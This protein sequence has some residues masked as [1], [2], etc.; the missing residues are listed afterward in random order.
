[1]RHFIALATCAVA[2]GPARGLDG[3]GFAARLEVQA[4][5]AVVSKNVRTRMSS[6]SGAL[7][8]SGWASNDV[9]GT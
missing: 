3:A 1:M 7:K 9:T 4:R 6:I 5:P 8:P 2:G